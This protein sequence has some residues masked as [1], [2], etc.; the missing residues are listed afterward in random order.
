MPLTSEKRFDLRKNA[1]NLS[2]WRPTRRSLRNLAKMM[3]H[4]TREKK[5]RMAS[6][7]FAVAPVSRKKARR[8]VPPGRFS[9]ETC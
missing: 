9:V 7:T 1:M 8:D 4:E 6:T 2:D 3:I 5:N